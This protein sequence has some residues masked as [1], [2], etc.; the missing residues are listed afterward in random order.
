MPVPPA[1]PRLYHILH[2]DRLPSVIADG[3]LWSDAVMASRLGAGTVI[4]M[5]ALKA[6]R[7]SL[8]VPCHSATHVGDYVP[9]YF[10]PRS[11]MLYVLHM[12]NHPGLAYRGGQ[13]PIVHLEFD[14]HDVVTWA[15]AKAHPWAFTLSNAAAAYASFRD[16][17]AQLG[18]INWPAV[19]STDFR[20]ADV[21]EGKQAEFLVHTS[22]PW[23]LVRRVGV[24]SRPAEARVHAAIAVTSH[25]PVVSIRTDWYY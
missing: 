6:S 10:C 13:A 3:C 7:L 17:L 12:A 19:A 16:D 11:V 20:S 1:H 18:D 21:K 2:V 22:V 9:F 8:P 24:H 4:G 15:D 23:S 5:S 25:R 14:L